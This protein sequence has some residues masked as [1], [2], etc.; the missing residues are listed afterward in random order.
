[1]IKVLTHTTIKPI[2]YQTGI[3]MP[4]TTDMVKLGE[5]YANGVASCFTCHS[6]DL[7]K[8]NDL[9]PSKSF[10]Y[11]AGGSVLTDT[12]GNEVIS[13][14]I[15]FD[16]SGIA[17]YSEEDFVKAVRFGQKPDGTMVRYPMVPHPALTDKE[18]RA[19]YAFLKTVPKVKNEVN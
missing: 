10:G 8:I 12:D 3:A 11:Y 4:D 17:H 5:Y 15:T 2:P 6:G 14:N 7:T 18:V 19:I 16:K 1:L 13:K 9:N